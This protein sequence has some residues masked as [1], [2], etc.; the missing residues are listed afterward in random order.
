MLRA[1]L[2]GLILCVSTWA[3]VEPIEPV[4][5]VD[6]PLAA[7]PL[8]DLDA[9]AERH[10]FYDYP[11]PSDVR[12]TAQGAPDL[13]NFYEPVSTPLLAGLRDDIAR[14]IRGFSQ[15]SGVYFRF[16]GPLDSASLPATSAASVEPDATVFIIDVDESS[17][18]FGERWPAEVT[19]YPDGGRY[20]TSNILVVRPP[21]TMP[22]WPGTRYAA[23]VVRGVIDAEG[24]LV[25]PAPAFEELLADSPPSGR[26]REWEVAQPVVEVAS[27]QGF[28][29]D[30]LVAT[31]FTTSDHVGEMRRL[32]AWIYEHVP[33]PVATDWELVHGQD[34]TGFALYTG[35]FEMM[36]FLAGEP[37]YSEEGTGVILFDDQGEP[38][39]GRTVSVR[40]G[41]SIPPGPCPD[42]GW[43]VAIFSHGA[44]G[45]YLSFSRSVAPWAAEAGVAMLSMSNTMQGDRDPVGVDFV[46]YLVD[47]AMS[48]V[49]A[50]R[51]MYRHG[52]PDQIQLAR[53]A[54]NLE[55]PAEVSHDGAA[56]ELDASHL[57]FTSHSMG[58][59][60][61]TMLVAVEPEVRSAFF[62]EGGGGAVAAFLFRKANDVDIEALVALVL[63]V[64]VDEEP[65]NADHPVIGL[66]VQ[67]L[68]DPADPMAYA[69][70]AIRDP[71]GAPTSILMTEG[72][73]D[74][75]TV[76]V[77]IESLAAAY[78]IPVVAPM[79]QP[80][81]AHEL[82]GIP[83]EP[84]PLVDNVR[85][86]PNPVTGGLLQ[87]PGHGHY[88]LFE[89]EDAQ[90]WFRGWLESAAA[91]APVIDE[92]E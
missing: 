75:Q 21:M 80:S 62:S 12:V 13:S 33:Q 38:L 89:N 6:D 41:L 8:F 35:R 44:G 43:P 74:D 22:L 48:N 39:P 81:T 47:L 56:I 52:I 17:P 15:S 63:G 54:G 57:T 20:F 77:S 50:G 25:A 46:E 2:I 32:R 23:V 51:D 5:P 34:D 84:P 87:F 7:R 36:D 59:Q 29:D 78:G 27:E 68:L 55:V 82:W 72:L 49:A 85:V 71:D 10:G 69:Y 1:A 19:F 83:P 58:S 66:I 24:R 42:G 79:A 90:T 9:T 37:P 40:F 88:A 30:L 28:V 92:V 67:T 65:L 60:I 4:E 16:S 70:G 31:V 91:G 61:G 86:G 14:D 3:C 64:D 26:E 73:E 11:L 76:P 18:R 45:D 53:L